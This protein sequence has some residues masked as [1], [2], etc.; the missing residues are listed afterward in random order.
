MCSIHSL[1]VYKAVN[2]FSLYT[3]NNYYNI[4]GRF[5]SLNLPCYSITTKNRSVELDLV[6]EQAILWVLSFPSNDLEKFDLNIYQQEEHSEE[7]TLSCRKKVLHV[8]QS[9]FSQRNRDLLLFLRLFHKTHLISVWELTVSLTI[10][11]GFYPA[12]TDNFVC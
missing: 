10:Q 4:S 6:T 1:A 8:S 5:S 12:N 11:C 2:K 3:F 7:E 9:M